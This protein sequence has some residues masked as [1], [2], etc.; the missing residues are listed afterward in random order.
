[1]QVSLV[2]VEVVVMNILAG[3]TQLSRSHAIEFGRCSSVSGDP[4]FHPDEVTTP[5]CTTLLPPQ[6]HQG[7]TFDSFV[8]LDIE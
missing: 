2:A 5:C 4:Y 6:D 1:M 7:R 3:L 8:K